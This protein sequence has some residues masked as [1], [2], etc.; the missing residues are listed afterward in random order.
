M[1]YIDTLREQIKACEIEI[2]GCCDSYYENED[3]VK[4]ALKTLDE[5]EGRIKALRVK[6]YNINIV[7][8][9][10]LLVID[11]ILEMSPANEQEEAIKRPFCNYCSGEKEHMKECYAYGI[12]F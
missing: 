5:F 11:T 1:N 6:Y 12:P 2:N 10:V 4:Q 3:Q 7:F 8:P 9:A